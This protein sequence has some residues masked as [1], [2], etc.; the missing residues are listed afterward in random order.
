MHHGA[1]RLVRCE[2]E[3]GKAE[4]TQASTALASATDFDCS[5]GSST[6]NAGPSTALASATVFDGFTPAGADD[7]YTVWAAN[8]QPAPAG[9]G[10]V[11]YRKLAGVDDLYIARAAN[12][13]PAQA[14]C[15][16]VA[17]R[18]LA[19]ADNLYARWR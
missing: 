3:K 10:V 11:A 8:R 4:K 9:C 12:R 14:V 16:V 19:G 15:G 7:L 13:Q 1:G 18:K 5:L 2:A 17:H 6:D